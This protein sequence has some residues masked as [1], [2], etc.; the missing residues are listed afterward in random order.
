MAVDLELMRLGELLGELYSPFGP[1]RPGGPS[2]PVGPEVPGGPR[3]P[4]APGRPGR[5]GRPFIPAGPEGPMSPD[6]PFQPGAPKTKHNG[7]EAGKLKTVFKHSQEKHI[8]QSLNLWHM[9]QEK[10]NTNQ[11]N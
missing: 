8:L 1:G 9:K 2:S 4:S 7:P 10:N 11:L 6:W 3:K 5:P